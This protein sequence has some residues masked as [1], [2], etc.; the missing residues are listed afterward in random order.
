MLKHGRSCVAK[1]RIIRPVCFDERT[2]RLLYPDCEFVATPPAG[3][4]SISVGGVVLQA[5]QRLDRAGVDPRRLRQMYENRLIAVAPGSKL[6]RA[7][8]AARPGAI[9]PSELPRMD[10]SAPEEVSAA[11]AERAAPSRSVPRRRASRAA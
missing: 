1:T 11:P 2:G 9:G 10:L 4:A 3:R 7:Q 8:R 5:G 6:V